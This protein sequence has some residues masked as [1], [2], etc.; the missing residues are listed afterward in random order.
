MIFLAKIH[1]AMI[2]L[3]ENLFDTFVVFSKG[4]SLKGTKPFLPKFESF[5]RG[6]CELLA[7]LRVK[8]MQYVVQ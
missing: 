6:L 8:L 5:Q 2:I 7:S 4:H 3:K 1:L